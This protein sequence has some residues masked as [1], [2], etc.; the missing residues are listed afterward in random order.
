M[1]ARIDPR[2]KAQ[3]KEIARHIVSTDRSARKYGRSQNT[4]GDITRAMTQ[5]YIIGQKSQVYV[6]L[7]DTQ[8][9][10]SALDWT[11]IPPRSRDTLESMSYVMSAKL[12]IGEADLWDIERIPSDPRPRW[13]LV[14]DGQARGD[15]TIANGGVAPLIRM[16]L[17][18][19]VS[20]SE[21]VFRLTELGK[22]TCLDYWRKSD[23]NDRTLPKI[24][25]R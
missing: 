6:E 3:F 18:E 13:R 1:S 5:A 16:K 2:L 25:L 10:S 11:T 8:Q 14:K 24:S 12:G 23:A 17:L 9:S 15:H 22:A 7:P 19:A 20:G 21:T 4:I